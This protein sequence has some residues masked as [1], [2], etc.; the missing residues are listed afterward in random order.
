MQKKCSIKSP[1]I[2]E[3]N[4]VNCAIRKTVPS[5]S[6][7]FVMTTNDSSRVRALTDIK[8]TL[9]LPKLCAALCEKCGKCQRVVTRASINDHYC[10][11]VRCSTCRKY[12]RPE[13]RRCYTSQ[14]RRGIEHLK[15]RRVIPIYSTSTLLL[16]MM[17]TTIKNKTLFF[18]ILNVHKTM[19]NTF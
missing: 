14:L 1:V 18:S 16:R 4:C 6:G 9:V 19:E 13:N 10:G 11:K 17:F 3:E 15:K 7:N 12:V 5:S 8:V 2:P